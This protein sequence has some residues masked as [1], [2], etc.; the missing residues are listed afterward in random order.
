MD[1]EDFTL[2]LALYRVGAAYQLELGHRDPQSQAEV[3]P[4]RSVASFDL[5]ALL[6]REANE[7][8]YGETLA[9]QLFANTKVKERFCTI[10]AA[11]QARSV[12]LRISL[13]ID[14]SGQ[15]LQAL[16]W[17]LLRHPETGARLTSSERVL[18]S[19]FMVSRDWRPVRLRSCR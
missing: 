15:E 12:G 19:R 8:A 10:E 2:T 17:E 13:S 7:R 14:P 9:S 1:V 6:A 16:R 18:L 4:L 5:P 11:A 3:A